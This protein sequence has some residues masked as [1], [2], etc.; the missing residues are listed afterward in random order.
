MPVISSPI[1]RYALLAISAW[2]LLV[3]CSFVW[4]SSQQK[5]SVLEIARSEARIAFQKDTLY[6]KWASMHGGVFVPVTPETQPNAYLPGTVERSARTP[7]GKLLTLINPAY[8]TRQVFE[9]AADRADL[10]RGH[11]TSLNPIRPENA[12]DQWE[13]AALTLL[14][15][16]V[17]EVSETSIIDGRHYLRLMRPFIAD[18]PCLK[19]HAVQ[20]Y[21]AGEIR[22][23]VSVSV[24]LAALSANSNNIIAGSGAAHGL[25]WLVGAG[26]ILF[27]SR[28]ISHNAAL[29]H[30]KNLHLEGEIVERQA[31]QEALEEQSVVLGEELVERKVAEAALLVSKEELLDQNDQ[32]LATE[33]M[34]RV[35]I[36]EFEVSQVLLKEAKIAAE[37]ASRAKSQFLAIMNHELRT[38]MNGVLGMAQLLAM[39][40]LTQEQRDYVVILTKSGK[41]LTLLISDILELSRLVDGTLRLEQTTFSLRA[42]IDQV[43]AA[44]RHQADEK[45][46]DFRVMVS[47]DVPDV[48]VGDPLRLRQ[49]LQNLVGNAVK[50]TE[51]G[52]VSVSAS[53]TE[54][55]SRTMILELAV[56]DTGIGIAPDKREVIFDPFIQVDASDTRTFGGA[57]LGLALCKRLTELMG[58]TI[59]VESTEGCGTL[60]QV[61][62]PFTVTDQ[63]NPQN[64]LLCTV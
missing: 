53:V 7:S 6:R 25:I 31:A 16:G 39:T 18:Q 37:A 27:G 47:P 34:L 38:P 43:A 26:M 41:N 35:Q 15:T 32:L 55:Q 54:R 20:G 14:E 17:Q 42:S 19:C 36:E 52:C 28:K 30:D 11:I 10:V 8:M 64:D 63:V 1:K 51:S 23:G 57:G 44:H 58:G 13:Q 2:T 45:G 33:E 22:G 59:H 49:I 9:L 5:Q 56:Q 50:F 21:K 46:L 24:P 3:A 12:P 48:L 4:T 61:L 60:F 29:L 62:I 40:D